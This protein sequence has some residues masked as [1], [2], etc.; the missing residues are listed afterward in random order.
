MNEIVDKV[1]LLEPK[2]AEPFPYILDFWECPE[3][4][5]K[6]PKKY[7]ENLRWRVELL[8]RAEDDEGLQQDL[9]TACSKSIL[10][11]VNAFCFTFKQF[12]INP[13]THKQV[14]ARYNHV[15]FITWA[16]QDKLILE[17]LDAILEGHD[18]V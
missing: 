5:F 9:M 6:V 11:F 3:T 4:G 18:L 17:V 2:L 12:D 1:K 16:I 14:P 15:P 8:R 10:F 7:E 13:I